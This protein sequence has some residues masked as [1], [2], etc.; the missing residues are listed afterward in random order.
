MQR[1]RPTKALTR[2]LVSRK[3]LTTRRERILV[4]QPAV[5]FRERRRLL[6]DFIQGRDRELPP[7]RMAYI[8]LRVRPEPA[9]ALLRD[10]ESSSSSRIVREMLM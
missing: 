4:N 6:S 3:T 5:C 7:K 8:S 2:T 10:S 1:P 9:A